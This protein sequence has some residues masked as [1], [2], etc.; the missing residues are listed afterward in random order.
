M[1]VFF[2][3]HLQFIFTTNGYEQNDSHYKF[4]NI[5]WRD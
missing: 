2:K 5:N 1:N 4:K 3:I